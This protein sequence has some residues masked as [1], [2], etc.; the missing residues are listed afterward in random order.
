MD[1][2]KTKLE[3]EAKELLDVISWHIGSVQLE[4]D[5]V[6]MEFQE[7]IKEVDE[8]K[9][10]IRPLKA[11]LSDSA[12]IQAAIASRKSR[13]KYFPEFATKNYMADEAKDKAFLEMIREALK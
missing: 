13:A 9:A 5:G 6:M 7:K 4:L 1:I 2:S 3:G 11:K 8:I 10:K 12:Q